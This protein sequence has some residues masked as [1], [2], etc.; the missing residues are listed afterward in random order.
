MSITQKN[1]S[2]YVSRYLKDC[3]GLEI[4]PHD[5]LQIYPWHKIVW[6]EFYAY[7]YYKQNGFYECWDD[8]P[9][10]YVEGMI[11]NIISLEVLDRFQYRKE[12]WHDLGS[13]TADCW[14]P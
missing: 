5:L 10:P 6:Y 8:V 11:V 9:T 3:Y 13:A 1:T 4:S 14:K 12:K 2:D 7:A